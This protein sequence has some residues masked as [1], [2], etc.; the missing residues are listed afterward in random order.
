LNIRFGT[1]TYH[2]DISTQRALK[3]LTWQPRLIVFFLLKLGAHD[4]VSGEPTIEIEYE[5]QKKEVINT[6][7]ISIGEILDLVQSKAQ[8]MDTSAKLQA[9][10]LAGQT[11]ESP[12]LEDIGKE[13][14]VG[15]SQQIPRQQ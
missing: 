1:S 7:S 6:S 12:W 9:A 14:H 2:C 10:G 8:E 15:Q 3:L 13:T 11:L 4:R 5:N